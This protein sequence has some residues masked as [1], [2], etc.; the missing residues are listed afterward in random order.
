MSLSYLTIIPPGNHQGGSRRGRLAQKRTKA[1]RFKIKDDHQPSRSSGKKE[2]T[3]A[4]NINNNNR[5][6]HH[7]KGASFLLKLGGDNRPVS[8]KATVEGG[9]LFPPPVP[10]GRGSKATAIVSVR[11]CEDVYSILYLARK[12]E[13]TFD[14]D[15]I[16]L[17]E[18]ESFARNEV[19]PS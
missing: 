12:R 4:N 16:F 1:N 9:K 11:V 19:E 8:L 7:L 5:H 15:I 14:F 17:R 2:S 6:N 10:R 13:P 18:C 3:I